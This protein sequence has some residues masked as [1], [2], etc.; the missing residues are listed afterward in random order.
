MA[1]S[2]RLIRDITPDDI[3]YNHFVNNVPYPVSPG[4]EWCLKTPAMVIMPYD[5]M[6]PKIPKSELTFC[7][8]FDLMVTELAYELAPSFKQ[9]SGG[10]DVA[11]FKVAGIISGDTFKPGPV[12]GVLAPDGRLSVKTIGGNKKVLILKDIKG[13]WLIPT[14]LSC[15]GQLVLVAEE[16]TAHHLDAWE[17]AVEASK[18]GWE[19]TSE[20]SKKGWEKTSEASKKG[21][22]KTTEVTA[23]GAEVASKNWAQFSEQA[24][25][26]L[27]DA[28]AKT[29]TA[30]GNCVDR[31]KS[32]IKN[33]KNGG[34]SKN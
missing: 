6:A 23:K 16:K 14:S 24:G 18:K 19:K 22:E 3:I 21:W 15:W 7:G 29:T 11:S 9:K 28:S 30:M 8:A 17:N 5:S 34:S 31:P 10:R 13:N 26:V 32:A 25:P 4:S 27:K 2:M 20:V 12:P 1:M 33:L